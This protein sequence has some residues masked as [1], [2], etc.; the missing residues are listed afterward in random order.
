MRNKWS[1]EEFFWTQFKFLEQTSFGKVLNIFVVLHTSYN[2]HDDKMKLFSQI[3]NIHFF[4]T[5]A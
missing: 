4:K 2:L 5:L 1:E 3:L